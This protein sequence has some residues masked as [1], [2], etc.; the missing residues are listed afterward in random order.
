M[1]RRNSAPT[2][3]SPGL[4]NW[5]AKEAAINDWL[6]RSFAE[7]K[8]TTRDEEE[9]QWIDRY[10]NNEEKPN[11]T[12]SYKAPSTKT[13]MP[14][15]FGRAIDWSLFIDRFKALAQDQKISP[16]E[17]LAA[18][19]KTSLRGPE[20][21]IVEGLG[22]EEAA[23]KLALLRLK[24]LSGCRD[25]MRA[26]YVTELNR[27]EPGYTS[28]TLRRFAEKVRTYLFELIRIGEPAPAQIIKLVVGK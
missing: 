11:W 28:M 5:D 27:L 10:C 17:K 21:D 14:I 15:F 9:H 25:V 3:T 23:Y 1:E 19:N 6:R 7:S 2:I 26:S 13:E 24:A 22:G 20:L 12:Y 4:H 18:L 8:P 16:G